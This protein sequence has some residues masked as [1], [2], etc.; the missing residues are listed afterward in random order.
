MLFPS[1]SYKAP[2]IIIVEPYSMRADKIN[3]QNSRVI[4]IYNHSQRK[5]SAQFQNNNP[6]AQLL[7]PASPSSRTTVVYEGEE[8]LF[9]TCIIIFLQIVNN[10]RAHLY[11]KKLILI[12]SFFG[13]RYTV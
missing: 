12:H 6:S 13:I 11:K 1:L 8:S 2:L 7:F 9:V 5:Y 10:A 4:V 3:H